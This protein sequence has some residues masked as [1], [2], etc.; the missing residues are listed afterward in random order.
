MSAERLERLLEQAR[1]HREKEPAFLRA[2]LEATVYAHA[3]RSDDHPRLRL[4]QFR[5]PDGFDVVPFFTSE[6]KARAAGQQAAVRIV[7]F[8]GRELFAGTPGATFM[9]NP[10]DGGCVLY[11]EEVDA[12]LRT[13]TVAR[14][15]KLRTEDEH[16]FLVSPHADP[17][18]WL[19]PTLVALYTKLSYVEAAFLLEVT[20]AQAPAERTWLVAL[21]VAPEHAERAARATIT[22]VQPLCAQAEVALDITTFDPATGQPAYLS[23]PGVERFYG[24]SLH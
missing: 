1:E 20:P 13:G 22:A 15:E 2:L 17:P 4:V 7:T 9:L 19:A 23:Q 16:A 12:L 3:P 8:T 24:P 6:A 21:A 5:H 11:P 10:N 18:T 14:I